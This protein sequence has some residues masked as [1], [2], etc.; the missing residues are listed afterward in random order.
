MAKG[1]TPK[2]TTFTQFKG[3]EKLLSG[4]GIPLAELAAEKA[5]ELASPDPAS[6]H[7][8]SNLL[9][10]QN[11]RQIILDLAAPRAAAVARSRVSQRSTSA[12]NRLVKTGR[13]PVRSASSAL[14]RTAGLVL[15]E[16]KRNLLL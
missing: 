1:F 11:K 15:G 13:K 7:H 6:G 16:E 10:L 4:L 9:I 2:R 5:R 14:P 3:G 12:I 8:S